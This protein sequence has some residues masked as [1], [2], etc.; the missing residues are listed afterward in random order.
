MNLDFSHLNEAQIK[1]VKKIHG[2]L[3]ILAGA[4]SGKT[5]VI[6]HRIANLITNENISPY[7]ICAMTFTN[8]AANEMKERVISLLPKF[9]GEIMVRTFHSL[10]LFIL[11]SNWDR[12][13]FSSNFTVYDSSLQESLI[14]EVVKSLK[15]DSKEFKSNSI[16]T[17][18]NRAKDEMLT[19]SN[20]FNTLDESLI[21][22]YYENVLKIFERYESY[23]EK[24]NAL[25]F[26]DLIFKTVQIFDNDKELLARYNLRW[27]YIMVDEFQDT[28][29]AQYLLSKQL[30]G[31][32]K[33]LCVV[34]DDDQS[35]YS[36]RGA[37]VRNILEFEKDFPDTFIVKLEENYRSSGNIIRAASNLISYN[38][39][40]TEKTIFTNNPDGDK[41]S[42]N[43]F[44]SEFDEAHGIIKKIK[45]LYKNT[46]SYSDFAVFYRTNSQSRYIEEALRSHGIPYKIF[47][48]F[49]FFDRAEIKDVIAYL[50]V[51]VNPLDSTSLLRIINSPPRGI[52]DT[53]LEKLK[54]VS[55]IKGISL[56]EVLNKENL[57]LKKGTLSKVKEFYLMM[58]DLIEKNNKKI[59]PSSILND[60]II[61]AGFKEY[62]QK[63][64]SLESL[65]RLENLQEFVNSLLD[66]ED[67]NENATL[68]EYLNSI[69][70]LTSEEEKSDLSDYV[71]LMTMHNSKGL[72][73]EIVFIAGLEEGTFPHFMVIDGKGDLEEER[74]LCYVAITRARKKLF[75]THVT[76]K[77]KFGSGM[78]ETREP[79]RFLNEIPK[80]LIQ[81]NTDNSF[82]YRR[83]PLHPP[84]SSDSIP[85][86]Q[87]DKSKSTMNDKSDIY[88]GQKVIHKDY[89]KGDI[90]SLTGAGDNR[91]AK[92]RFGNIDKNFLLAY[93]KLDFL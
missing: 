58:L 14:T 29:H 68:D 6:T 56:F 80:E 37:D 79:S 90:L 44:E 27:K 89:G 87:M 36:W 19:P 78:Y 31:D 92:I 4:G 60:L 76:R 51:I 59:L 57:D 35:I 43:V 38:S 1:A 9:S 73:Y 16:S 52:G 8:K 93:T 63:D 77:R 13:G 82:S 25:D 15:L 48:G 71:T 62:F 54:D 24:Q 10:C 86:V 61:R 84:L 18:I 49:R 67:E 66:Y 74:R 30:A 53:S 3:L 75:L 65:N 41:I 47:G 22:R 69:S 64:D 12:L 5:R 42:L 91:K 40:R 23:K 85:L 50:N 46:S 70:L 88:I 20:W 72:E 39:V 7:S 45:E 11:R 28:N 55:R 26:G 32:L 33:N 81:E 2:P 83:T 17:I 21:G 34:G